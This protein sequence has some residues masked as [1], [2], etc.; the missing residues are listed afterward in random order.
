MLVMRTVL[1]VNMVTNFYFLCDNMLNVTYRV[2]PF[3]V[4]MWFISDYIVP[5]EFIVHAR[6]AYI[7]YMLCV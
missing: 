6:I 1:I 2:F 3:S 4:K 7:M 5:K